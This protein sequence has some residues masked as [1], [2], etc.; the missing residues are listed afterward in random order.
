ML[1]SKNEWLINGKSVKEPECEIIPE[2]GELRLCPLE[3]T[4]R[5][6]ACQTCF[7]RYEA[8]AA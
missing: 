1:L 2:Y 5:Q 8:N 6:V 7:L 4:I 3:E